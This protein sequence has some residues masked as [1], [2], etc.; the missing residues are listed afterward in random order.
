MSKSLQELFKNKEDLKAVFWTVAVAL[1]DVPESEKE[2]FDKEFEE[3]F[4]SFED[5]PDAI[6]AAAD[7][8]GKLFK[9]ADVVKSLGYDIS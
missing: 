2:N 9:I 8:L 3:G 1:D 4:E 5:D 6:E 7:Q